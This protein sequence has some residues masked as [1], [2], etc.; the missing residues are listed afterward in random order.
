MG[1]V[2]VPRPTNKL[3]D[4]GGE[5][6][7]KQMRTCSVS[8]KKPKP[9]HLLQGPGAGSKPTQDHYALAN[10]GGPVVQQSVRHL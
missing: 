4:A 9:A 8:N 2:Y 3:Q 5:K 10:E 7:V 6:L 1:Q